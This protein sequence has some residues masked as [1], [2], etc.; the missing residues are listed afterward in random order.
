MS[1]ANYIQLNAV[2]DLINLLITKEELIVLPVSEEYIVFD[3][4][5][6]GIHIKL[7]SLEDTKIISPNHLAL[8]DFLSQIF[9]T[10]EKIFKYRLAY[11]ERI[12]YFTSN[13]P[14]FFFRYSVLGDEGI[15][16]CTLQD[17]PAF[18]QQFGEALSLRNVE[19]FVLKTLIENPP[20]GFFPALFCISHLKQ[21]NIIFVY[22]PSFVNNIELPED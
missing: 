21:E 7:S 10:P 8:A 19:L 18:Y 13:N 1:D 16:F 9:S 5:A 17:L 2:D 4:Q 6:Q 14:F 12:H 20:E 15:W 3:E 11:Q 22:M